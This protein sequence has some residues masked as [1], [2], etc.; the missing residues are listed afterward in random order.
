MPCCQYNALLFLWSKISLD[1]WPFQ[2]PHSQT[3]AHPYISVHSIAPHLLKQTSYFPALKNR[4]VCLD[5]TH[6]LITM[7]CVAVFAKKVNFV[8][9]NRLHILSMLSD[10]VCIA[11]SFMFMPLGTSYVLQYN[12]HPAWTEM[13]R[14]K[15]EFDHCDERKC[16]IIHIKFRFNTSLVRR[17]NLLCNGEGKEAS[18]KVS[19]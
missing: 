19:G 2:V 6:S 8:C 9:V 14:R 16:R 3:L 5:F 1:Q 13:I 7:R 15:C 17:V 12:F 4:F 18:V 10:L 11:G